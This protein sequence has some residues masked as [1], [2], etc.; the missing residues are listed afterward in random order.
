MSVPLLC[1]VLIRLNGLARYDFQHSQ[2]KSFRW[3]FVEAR[4]NS[5][6]HSTR[7]WGG[8]DVNQLD[9]HGISPLFLLLSHRY[10]AHHREMIHGLLK[11][12]AVIHN[13][14]IL[15][16]TQLPK[17]LTQHAN[18]E[19]VKKMFTRLIPLAAS[20]HGPEKS[21]GFEH[22]V[23]VEVGSGDGYLCYLLELT[24]DP[25]LKNIAEKIVETEIS[26]Q[27]VETNAAQGK[28]TLCHVFTDI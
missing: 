10:A 4:G 6:T 5:L 28:Y 22:E 19:N 7:Q 18:A 16:P 15:S 13:G 17:R 27:I 8:I 12:G 20:E 11:R 14:T 24:G 26:S 25:L 9:E 3:K 21:H 1:V 23:L 2:I